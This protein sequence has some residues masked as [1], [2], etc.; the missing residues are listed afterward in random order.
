MK[1]LNNFNDDYFEKI[2]TEDKAYFLGLLFADGNIYTKRHR[3]QITLVNEDAYILKK[4]A[5]CIGYTGKMY[6]D[7][8]KYS[9]LILPSK[10]MCDDLT[11][12]GCTERKSLTLKFPS[13]EQVPKHLLHHFIRGCFD[14][15]GHISK[16]KKLVN[17]YYHINITSSEG[18]IQSLRDELIENKIVPAGTY[19]RYKDKEVS[20][21]TMMIKSKSA[22]VFLDY[23]YKDA[24]IFLT[25]KH[26]VYENM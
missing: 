5:D 7:R 26:K 3:V 11:K 22:K 19:K 18:F 13:E 4:F 24:N 10:K 17:P 6:I 23:L 8:E 16:D 9:K 21:H 25:R 12:L 1:R 14:G 20:A 15:D 2:D